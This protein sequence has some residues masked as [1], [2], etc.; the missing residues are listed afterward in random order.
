VIQTQVK[1][2]QKPSFQRDDS[3]YPREKLLPE[4]EEAMEEEAMEEEMEEEEM[5]MEEE[6][7]EMEEEEMVKLTILNYILNTYLRL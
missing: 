6:E 1:K 4:E 3:R 5:E 2:Q 7:M